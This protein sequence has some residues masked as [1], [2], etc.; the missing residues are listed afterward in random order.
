M[1]HD[2]SILVLD[3]PASGLDPRARVEFRELVKA[4]AEMKKAILVS[5]HIL[6]ELSEICHGVAVIEAGRIQATG[7]V[8]SVVQ[9]VRPHA[10]IFLRVLGDLAGAERALAEQPGV[11]S[12]RHD[13]DGLVFDYE[14]S[15]E[16]RS[17]LLA[18]L[19]RAGLRPIEFATRETDLEDVFLRL[20]EGRV[21]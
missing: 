3:E 18:Q 14:G 1:L 4:L 11:R 20:T 13:R 2:P 19:V 17:E 7:S 21:Q 16:E 8:A 10:E 15:A 6:S 5:S 12:V 9:G